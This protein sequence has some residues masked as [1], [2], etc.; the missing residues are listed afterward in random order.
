MEKLLNISMF[1]KKQFYLFL[2]TYFFIR[3]FSYFFSPPTPLLHGSLVNTI[4]SLTI[5]ALSS[6]WILKKDLRGWLLVAGEIIFCGSGNILSIFNISL[7]TALLITSLSLFFISVWRD[8]GL[9]SILSF[10]LPNILIFL[11]IDW[12]AISA[13]HG[14]LNGNSTAQ[15]IS[16][17]IPYLFFL[18]YFPLTRLLADLKFKNVCFN[19]ITAVLAANVIFIVY[20]FISFCFGSLILQDNYYHW[21]RDVAQGKIT[22][23]GYN[24]IR[25]VLNEHLVLVPIILFFIFRNL[26]NPKR[27]NDLC[28][29]AGALLLSLNLTRIYF[30]ALI[31][32]L[33]ALFLRRHIK[34]WLLNS[35]IL[36]SC[37]FI[38]YTGFFLIASN[39]QD[40]GWSYFGFRISS[41][42]MPQTELSSLSR[43][44]LLPQILYKIHLAPFV[45]HGLGDTVT[46]QNFL[47]S[48]STITTPHFDWGY[49][50]ILDETG[51]IGGI[52]WLLIIAYIWRFGKKNRDEF[53]PLYKSILLSL[54]VINITSP[55]LFHVL[56]ITTLTVLLA[57]THVSS[58]RLNE[59]REN[60][61]PLSS[62]KEADKQTSAANG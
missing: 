40:P 7:R 61:V 57:L 30:L 39:G 36:L 14:A 51:L 38:F 47:F 41:I 43:M 59:L 10:K 1:V 26:I 20:T 29:L 3:I 11:L 8:M 6:Y 56:G 49:L 2:L 31:A 22:I 19:M 21:F 50:E 46:V 9:K 42:A 55:A 4:F 35:V 60:A 17:F 12:A 37:I 45:G 32:G 58:L 13:A 34:Q 5:L 53:R 18:Y 54:L 25:L 33:I 16:D 27:I 23:I 24:F 28:I 52:L 15:I 48:G 44:V 62:S